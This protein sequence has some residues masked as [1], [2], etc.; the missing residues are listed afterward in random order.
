MILG[1]PAA[2]VGDRRQ[3]PR[4]WPL[5]MRARPLA[6]TLG[7]RGWRRQ[8]GPSCAYHEHA[9]YRH[10]LIDG[11]GIVR[12][13]GIW[14]G[15]AGKKN[16]KFQMDYVPLRRRVRAQHSLTNSL[17]T[18]THPF[19]LSKHFRNKMRTA[20]PAGIIEIMIIVVLHCMMI[21]II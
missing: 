21:N 18:L 15:G 8:E 3:V 5:A 14:G 9:L 10:V 4:P 12:S 17:S 19:E 7:H 2:V 16:M 11:C 1:A 6:Q 13:L 20:R